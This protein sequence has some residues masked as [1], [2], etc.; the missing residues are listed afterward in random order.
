MV[1]EAVMR[2]RLQALHGF[3]DGMRQRF[4]GMSLM[5]FVADENARLIAERLLHLACEAC[6]D[7]ANHVL[8][9]HGTEQAETYRQTFELL[10][11]HGFVPP[12]L[13][14]SLQKMAVMRNILVHGYLAV[15]PA[16]VH[17]V[18]VHRLGDLEQFAASMAR[19]C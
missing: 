18:V 7:I 2:R 4:S 19:L 9:S 16:K 14:A 3:L 15:D 13:A 8:A 1:D 17:D 11:K 5:A 6:I 10:G 12:D